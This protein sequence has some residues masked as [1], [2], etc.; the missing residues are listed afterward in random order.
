LFVCLFEFTQTNILGVDAID[1]SPH[2]LCQGLVFDF[3]FE[4]KPQNSALVAPHPYNV[5]SQPTK[6][7][8]AHGFSQFFSIVK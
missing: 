1:R 4:Q 8:I 5:T 2:S 7:T 3:F 6:L